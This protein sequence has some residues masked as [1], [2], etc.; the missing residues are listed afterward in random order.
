MTV[1]LDSSYAMAMALP[2]EVPPVTEAEVLGQDLVAP[3]LFPVEIANAALNSVRRH[4][5]PPEDADKVCATVE[6]LRVNVVAPSDAGPRYFARLALA[7]DLSAYDAMY[8]DLA[9]A[10]R[11]PLATADARLAAAARRAGVEVLS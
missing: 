8:L 4:R 1:V 10:L 3:H 11:C 7:H 9:L 6:A 5:Y 2:D